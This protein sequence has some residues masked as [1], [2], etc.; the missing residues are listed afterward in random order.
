MPRRLLVDVTPLRESPAYR[1]LWVGS[2]L[3]AAGSQM[4]G[5]A[6]ALQVF[7]LTHSPVAVGGVGLVS[8]LPA[9]TCGLLA[10]S[11]VDA[12]DRRLLVLSTSS[13]QLLV[14]VAFAVQA[15]AGAG[16]LWLLYLLVA[17]QS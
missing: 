9:I 4:T 17:V 16:Q 11:L 7:L 15:F 5:F 10:G 1:R 13:V 2:L 3:S 6:V 8:A 12:H 14:S